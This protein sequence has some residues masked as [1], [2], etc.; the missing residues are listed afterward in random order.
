MILEGVFVRESGRDNGDD[1]YIACDWVEI[2]WMTSLSIATIGF[3]NVVPF[4][5]D[6]LDDWNEIFLF[7]LVINP[8]NRMMKMNMVAKVFNLSNLYSL[9]LQRKY[10]TD[11][12]FFSLLR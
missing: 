7:A 9:A 10:N 12:I 1:V 2:M 11:E 3:N 8:I 6:I 4:G 5:N